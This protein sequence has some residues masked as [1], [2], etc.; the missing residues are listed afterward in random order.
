[1]SSIKTDYESRRRY[2]HPS[3]VKM[4]QQKESPSVKVD[5]VRAAK[6]RFRADELALGGRHHAESNALTNAHAARHAR[7]PHVN[8][9]DEN[10]REHK[11]LAERHAAERAAQRQRNQ[12]ALDALMARQMPK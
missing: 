4:R 9:D 6:Q 11:E 3:S 12:A 7:E 5:P 2:T 1:M 8:R 10:A